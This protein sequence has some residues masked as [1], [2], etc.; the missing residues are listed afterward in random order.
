M[1]LNVY[2]ALCYYKS[3][4]FDVSLEVLNSYL[5]KFPDS[6]TAVNLKACSIYKKFSSKAAEEELQPILDLQ[7][8]SYTLENYL[9]KHNLVVF[10][11][12]ENALQILPSLVDVIPEAKLNLVIYYLRNDEV[13]EAYNLIK[14]VEAV[15]PQEYILKAIVHALVG[16]SSQAAKDHLQKAQSLFQVVGSSQLEC[17]TIPGRQCMASYYFLRKQY[18]DTLVYL[19][20]IKTFFPNHDEFNW[21]FGLAQAGAGLYKEAEATLLQVHNEKYKQ[22]YCYISWLARCYIMNNTPNF[23]W[24][25]YLKMETS[26]DSIALLQLIANDC[27]KIGSFYYAAKAFDV[28]ERLD[29]N[30]EYWEGKK[31]ACIG[32][33]QQVCA[34]KE[35][36]ELLKEAVTMLKSNINT[37]QGNYITQVIRKYAKEHHMLV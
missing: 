25:L 36:P 17:D 29:P 23:A 12:G 9:I 10:R 24:E 35:Q 2:I 27:Y 20:S 8:S 30:P 4:Y 3:D 16:H 18:E 31:G 5:A 37:P 26:S 22:E 33:L 14:D 19:K 7:Y 15:K 1:A 13:Q 21:N 11:D 32:V 6:P 28:L 34:G